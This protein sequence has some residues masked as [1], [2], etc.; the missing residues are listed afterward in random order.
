MAEVAG[1]LSTWPTAIAE[2][3]EAIPEIHQISL[4]GSRV[5]GTPRT[6]SDL[7][8]AVLL[9][10]TRSREIRLTTW[11]T[12]KT[13]WAAELQSRLPVPVHLEL[14]DADLST[15]VVGPALARE[16]LVIFTRAGP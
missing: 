12:R 8:I 16:G 2:W 15:D 7:D 14:G 10:P 9:D 4:F 3:A 11:L 5:R 6:D 13:D 1:N